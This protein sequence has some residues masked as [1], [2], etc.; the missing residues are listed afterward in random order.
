MKIYFAFNVSGTFAGP[1]SRVHNKTG[2]HL[3]LKTAAYSVLG[4]FV[5]LTFK[6][7]VLLLTLPALHFQHYQLLKPKIM[8]SCYLAM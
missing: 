6:S 1:Q 8:N 4:L 2:S 5:F 7:T 3:K